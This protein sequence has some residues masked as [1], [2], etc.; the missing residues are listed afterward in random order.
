MS[1]RIAASIRLNGR[2]TEPMLAVLR[3]GPHEGSHL[4]RADR[5]ADP[6]LERRDRT[7]VERRER[8]RRVVGAVEVDDDLIAVA[9]DLH[10][11]PDLVRT[12]AGRG[13]A[14]VDVELI[15]SGCEHARP[16][17]P[18][19]GVPDAEADPADAL[20]GSLGRCGRTD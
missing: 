16:R 15:R 14:E 13:I 8:A 9:L 17:E 3:P 20:A 18:P 19:L 12:L 4:A 6:V 1:A 5:H 2:V 7:V 10:I 11:P